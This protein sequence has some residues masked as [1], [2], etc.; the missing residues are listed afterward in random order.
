MIDLLFILAKVFL[1]VVAFAA[2]LV[3]A[4]KWLEV[5]AFDGRLEDVPAFVYK[6]EDLD[7]LTEEELG[8]DVEVVKY[9]P[10]VAPMDP[11]DPG[12]DH[13]LAWVATEGGALIPNQ[14][15]KDDVQI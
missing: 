13:D 6:E 1:V 5:D 11:D 15:N 10:A 7:P 8:G 3:I 4:V 2:I 12:W 14:K 9:R